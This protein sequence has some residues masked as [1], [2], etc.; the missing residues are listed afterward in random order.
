MF[1]ALQVYF[2]C[3]WLF[4]AIYFQIKLICFL[5]IHT[6]SNIDWVFKFTWPNVLTSFKLKCIQIKETKKVNIAIYLHFPKAWFKDYLL[7]STALSYLQAFYIQ[8]HEIEYGNEIQSHFQDIWIKGVASMT[9][10]TPPWEEWQWQHTGKH[11]WHS[12]L[13]ANLTW[14]PS[15]LPPSSP[16]PLLQEQNY[17]HLNKGTI[18][19]TSCLAHAGCFFINEDYS[20]H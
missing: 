17:K 14:V 2:L 9:V 7:L 1:T 5:L 20:D 8:P 11:G 16:G 18:V 6:D 3:V 12:S 15:L 4:S 19:E 10:N 13:Q